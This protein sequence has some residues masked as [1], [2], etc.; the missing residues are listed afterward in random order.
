MRA[1]HEALGCSYVS[2]T[3]ED[4]I[5]LAE[6]QVS[7]INT[8]ANCKKPEDMQFMSVRAAEV[9]KQTD[10]TKLKDRKSPPNHL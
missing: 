2:K 1:A 9:A 7:V 4:Y 10:E 8:M 6:L 5:S 3:S